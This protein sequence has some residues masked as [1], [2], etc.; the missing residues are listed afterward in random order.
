MKFSDNRGFKVEFAKLENID[1]SGC[2]FG[3]RPYNLAKNRFV[4]VPTFD[5]TRVVLLEE[6]RKP[7]IEFSLFPQDRIQTTITRYWHKL[8]LRKMLR[9]G[10]PFIRKQ[11]FFAD[12]SWALGNMECDI[13]VMYC[14]KASEALRL[15]SIACGRKCR[16]EIE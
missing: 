6:N 12:R 9:T 2:S 5:K 10:I 1:T 3:N 16:S 4:N 13:W 15:N 11:H 7:G 14:C 8:K